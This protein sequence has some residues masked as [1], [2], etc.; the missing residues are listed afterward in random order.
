[1]PKAYQ[2]IKN[3]MKH[4][5]WSDFG[6]IGFGFRSIESFGKYD[7]LGWEGGKGGQGGEEGLQGAAGEG[8]FICT[9]KTICLVAL[10]P[11]HS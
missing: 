5:F 7:T 4:K 11:T 1:M 6:A 10:L 8:G 3:R 2:G 9:S